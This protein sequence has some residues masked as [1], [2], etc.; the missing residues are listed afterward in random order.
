MT[1]S[2]ADLASILQVSPKEIGNV[3]ARLDNFYRKKSEPKPDGGVRTFYIP[4]GRLRKI[5]DQIKNRILSGARFPN[6]L[7]GGIKGKSVHTNVKSHSRKQAVL[8]LDIKGFFPNIRP[9][10]VMKVFERLGYTGEACRIL[11]SLT[12]YKYQLPQGPPTSP[13]IANLSIPR[14]D[15]RLNGLARSQHFDNGRFMDD[16]AIS[17]SNRLAKFRGLTGRIVQED[18]FSIKQGP[19]GKLMFQNE[20]QTTTGLTLNFKVNVPRKRRQTVLKESAHILKAG[21]PLDDATRGKLAWINST[22]PKAGR[23]L[24]RAARQSKQAAQQ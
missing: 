7:H 23:K 18:G 14:I 9:E 24:V 12:T 4:Q 20:S 15:A 16:M 13:A 6:Y 19:K 3:I 8:A 1:S 21:L 17:G 22:N 2:I 10:R 5:Q 11:T